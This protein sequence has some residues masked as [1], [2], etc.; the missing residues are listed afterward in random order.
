MSVFVALIV[1][2]ASLTAAVVLDAVQVKLSEEDI[3]YLEEPYQPTKVFG[4]M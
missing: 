1:V 4:H 2:F 3:K